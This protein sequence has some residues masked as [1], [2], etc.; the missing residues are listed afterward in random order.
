MDEES[1][2]NFFIES[3][4]LKKTI[5]YSSCPEKIQESTAGHSWQVTLMVPI[6][7][8]ELV[9]NIDISHAME[10]ANVH[11]LAEYIDEKDYDAYLVA[12]GVLDK[13][14]KDKSEET[15]MSDLKNRFNF[16]PTLYSLWKEYNEGKT[17]EARFVKALDKIESHIHVIERGGTSNDIH[18]AKYQAFYADDA[19]RNFPELKPFLKAIK[20]KLRP[21]LEENGLIWKEEYNYP[22]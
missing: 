4:K 8:R 13:R 16:G 20:K 11:D 1:L 14:E 22:D 10:I 7:A 21:V 19:I 18:D 9:L 12:T 15:V 5:R 3:N 2:V 6:I 17:P